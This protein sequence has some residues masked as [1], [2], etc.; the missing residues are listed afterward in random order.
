MVC[1]G[2]D[3]QSSGDEE[4]S[5]GRAKRSRVEGMPG[6]PEGVFLDT[7]WQC[8]D[9]DKWRKQNAVSVK[10]E[11]D[12]FTCSLNHDPA[13]ASCSL[14]EEHFSADGG[15]Q[16]HEDREEGERADDVDNDESDE[17]LEDECAHC[18]HNNTCFTAL[19]QRWHVGCFVCIECGCS[20]LSCEDDAEAEEASAQALSNG[21]WGFFKGNPYCAEHILKAMSDPLSF[22]TKD[23]ALEEYFS[24][25]PEWNTFHDLLDDPER[26]GAPGKFLCMEH[27]RAAINE[28]N[29]PLLKRF[30]EGRYDKQSQAMGMAALCN[31]ELPRV[32]RR[33]GHFRDSLV[34][35][36]LGMAH[37]SWLRKGLTQDWRVGARFL[38]QHMVCRAMGDGLGDVRVLNARSCLGVPLNQ[39]LEFVYQAHTH[40]LLLERV[41][42]LQLG[43]FLG[44]A[45]AC[46]QT[47]V[48]ENHFSTIVAG[49]GYKPSA[50]FIFQHIN[51][52]E[53]VAS[54]VANPSRGWNHPISKRKWKIGENHYDGYNDGHDMEWD[55]DRSEWMQDTRKRARRASENKAGP[56]EHS[57]KAGGLL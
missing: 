29:D 50:F 31:S 3:E 45:D 16:Q 10:N 34:L 43:T 28:M 20:L 7:W 14:E 51:T 18:C 56:R 21:T 48:N 12:Q 41:P 8:E 27:V 57:K 49:G 23:V 11:P 36:I 24:A 44:N 32:L 4:A 15:E 33:N 46:M 6:M 25:C 47:R 39:L 55:Q 17:E 53:A 1:S 2:D 38:L 5:I 54:I 40:V 22:E 52:F 13:F 42:E 37:Q 19:D 26:G 9:C 35:K 30:A